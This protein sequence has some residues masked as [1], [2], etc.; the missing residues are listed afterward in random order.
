MESEEYDEEETNRGWIG[1]DMVRL[2][3]LWVAAGA[4]FKLFTGSPN[5]LPP[6]VLQTSPLD[7]ITTFRLAIAVELCIVVL[8][9][10]RPR[11]AWLPLIALH[12]VFIAA[13]WPLVASGAESCGCFG[14]KVTIPP[15][16]MIGID[17]ALLIAILVT[18][19][20]RIV[21]RPF[22]PL[23]ILPLFVAVIAA[24]W[25]LFKTG[26]GGNAVKAV[27]TVDPGTDAIAVDSAPEASATG[28]RTPD[29]LPDFHWFE[30]DKWE[31]QEVHDLDLYR[32]LDVDLLPVDCHVVFY[33]QTCEHCAEHLA[34]LA[35]EPPGPLPLVLVRVAEIDDT[36]ENEVTAIKPD[37]ELMFELP[38][39]ERGYGIET[40]SAMDVG[41]WAV[42]RFEVIPHDDE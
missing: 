1:A 2:A 13:L 33:R 12:G 31:G 7:A 27:S 22:I 16:V 6:A 39:L 11:T 32:F 17:G 23:F 30:T 8:S 40:P 5:D 37:T 25:L 9:L 18:R 10:F 29:P 41:G 35:A 19:P 42:T 38:P 20:W 15:R 28:W 34:R 3:S 4:L 26:S 36:P 21:R 14:S 24:P